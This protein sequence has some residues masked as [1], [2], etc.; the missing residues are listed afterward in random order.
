MALSA[1]SWLD[2]TAPRPATAKE[3]MDE[4]FESVTAAL[5]FL[6]KLHKEGIQP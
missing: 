3:R 5:Q 4:L 6:D 1:L 2:K